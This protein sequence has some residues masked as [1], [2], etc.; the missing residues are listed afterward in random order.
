[1]RARRSEMKACGLC[2]DAG[3]VVEG[4]DATDFS[5]IERVLGDIR[6]DVIVNCIA[7]TKRRG[8]AADAL[9]SVELNA[10]FPHRLERWA[11]QH[12]A[13]LI[14]F[15]T[16][17]VFDGRAGNYD[18]AS[19]TNAE[20][21]YGRTKALG[22]VSGPCSLT[23]RTSLV[24]RELK[25]RTELLEW[26][27]AQKGRQISGY[28]RALYTGVSTV[29]MADLV[30][31]LLQRFPRLAGVHQVAAPTISKYDL[32]LLARDAFRVD[33]DI[34]P[35][36]SVVVLRNLD[37]T[38]FGRLTGIAVPDWRQMM[39]ELASDPTPYEDWSRTDAG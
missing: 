4:L 25:A 11:Q 16:D 22:E 30:A 7:I 12:S 27:L 29:W 21:L 28:R 32:L 13:R 18:E 38:R 14:H 34:Q 2:D 36:D 1:M 15:S 26:F 31:D 8:E 24:G 33:V 35:D 10:A 3:R 39:G 9:A 6:P 5:C 23:L 17:C 37:G 20:D 19:L